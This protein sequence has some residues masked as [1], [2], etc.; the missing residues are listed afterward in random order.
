[1]KF[2]QKASNSRIFSST[3]QKSLGKK[4]DIK[5]KEYNHNISHAVET[6]Q[7]MMHPL[8]FKSVRQSDLVHDMTAAL[9][10]KAMLDL[11]LSC[12]S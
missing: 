4:Y 10:F 2:Y 12:L 3:D 5:G 11:V 6:L 9:L 1:M 7:A 8:L